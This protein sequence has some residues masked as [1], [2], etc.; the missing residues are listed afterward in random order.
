MKKE[1]ISISGMTCASCA[2]AVER[3]VARVEGVNFASVNIATEKLNVEFDES[4]TDMSHI[5]ESI[6]KA[7]Y[8]IRSEEEANRE[9]IIPVSG[10]TCASCAKSVENAI[11][12]L[13]G[14]TDASVNLATEKVRVVYDPSKTRIS[15]IK[16]VII[17]AGYKPLE[18]EA[19]GNVDKDKERHEK[20][21]KSLWTRFLIA[22]IFTVPLFYIAMGHMLH[23]PLPE[24]IMPEAHPLSFGIIQLTLVIPV[25][26]A[27]YKFY[28]IGFSRLLRGE[29]NMD[30]LIAIGTG[31]AFIYGIYAIIQII[32]GKHEYAMELYFET[33]GMIITLIMLGKY[34]ESVSK[35]KTSEA[36][37]KLMGL[38]PKTAT[39]I[40]DGNE[41]MIPIDEVEVGD[42]IL[43]KPG[44]KIPVDGEV[45]SGRTSVDESMLTGESIPIEK[46][47]GSSV[48][49]ASINK[50]GTIQFKAT[51]VGKDTALA[52]TF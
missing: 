14:I 33:T 48:V 43:V 27:G 29:P 25:M 5:I 22:V 31:A 6:K 8:G 11:Q 10:M 32:N 23:F 41:M 44:E 9:V 13:T 4:R 28:T 15:E 21:S 46:N 26:I 45:V 38:A 12:K 47:K 3:S 42:I 52:Q 51:K 40:Q 30:S 20:E 50:N 7:G 37:K 18:I 39:V 36:I 1:V 35:G 17:K 49:G 2:K 34:L 16:Q 24:I 19:G